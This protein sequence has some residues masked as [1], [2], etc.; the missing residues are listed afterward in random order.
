MAAVVER[1]RDAL[2]RL[3]QLRGG[4]IPLSD[5][6]ALGGPLRRTTVV[7][8]T[9]GA[10]ILLLAVVAVWRA[11][12][13]GARPLTFLPARSTSEIVLDQS[14]SID[15]AAYRRVAKL[16]RALVAANNPVGLV[17][18][19]DTAYELMP[20]GSPGSELA[21]VLRYYIPARGAGSNVDPTTLFPSNP[22]EDVFSGGT[23]ISTGVDLAYSALRRDHVKGGTIVLASDLETDDGDLPA[24][25]RALALVEHDPNVH[26]KV[27]GLYPDAASLAFFKRFVPN[28]DFID[29]SALQVHQAGTVHRRLVGLNPWALLV[30]G[31][32]LLVALAFNEVVG[33]R[34]IVPHPQGAP[35]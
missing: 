6:D 2:S 10:A 3:A 22:W 28:Q 8:Y 27:L 24:L 7:R 34:V 26:L 12:A 31:G 14:K 33:S 16:L 13:L 25:A 32:L 18:F 5:A 23:A 11:A 4:A 17:A 30:V 29:P 9:L 35:Q 1:A 20:P 15:I 21:P 19:S